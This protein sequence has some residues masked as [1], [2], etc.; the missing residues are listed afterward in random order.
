M[1]E[2]RQFRVPELRRPGAR[3]RAR[4]RVAYMG[5]VIDDIA[6]MASADVAIGL[7]EDE[8]GF[9]SKTVCDVILGG[10][11][12]WLSRLFVLSR[13]YVQANRFNMNLIVGSSVVLAAASFA[14]TFSPLQTIFLFNAA[15]VI[16]EINTLRSLNASSSRI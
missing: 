2:D 10:D 13:R 7:A 14:A 15:P 9:I 5:D 1:S 11:F 3:A 6:A 8:K 16:A 4:A 12:L